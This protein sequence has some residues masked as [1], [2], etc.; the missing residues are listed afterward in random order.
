MKIE[1]LADRVFKLLKGNGYGIQ[2]FSE[3][4]D[5]TAIPSEGTRF[6]VKNPNLMV[7]VS[8]DEIQVNKNS[9]LSVDEIGSLEKAL[10]LLANESLVNYTIRNF[11]KEINARAYSYQAKEHK[12]MKNKVSEAQLSKLSGFRKTSYQT[13]GEVKLTYRHR[14]A[15]N[16]ESPVSRARNIHSIMIE[17]QGQKYQFPSNYVLGA[18]AMAR[19]LH[20]GGEWDDSAGNY[21]RE[22]SEQ[23]SKL[24]EFYIYANR[25]KHL[26]EG[27]SNAVTLVKENLDQIRS[28]FKKFSAPRTYESYRDKFSESVITNEENDT[29][30]IKDQFTI[31]TFNSKLESILPYIQNLLTEKELYETNIINEIDGGVYMTEQPRFTTVLEF[32]N[33]MSALS[34]KLKETSLVLES[35][36]LSVFLQRVSEKISTQQKLEEFEIK[37]V[38]DVLEKASVRETPICESRKKDSVDI[39]LSE[40]KR[41]VYKNSDFRKLFG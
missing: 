36:S 5:E 39:A 12:K 32:D 17:N 16:E 29:N 24:R 23:Y 41:S 13:L 19:H 31:K 33:P 3:D 30:T 21:I 10:K 7:S 25:N 15:V 11:G 37:V 4:G 2:I 9:S 6:F 40:F 34:Y 14:K 8:E 28:D 22:K 20:E 27:N 1:K 26:I 35:E 38:K 18:R